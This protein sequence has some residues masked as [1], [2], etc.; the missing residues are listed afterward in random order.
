MF[1]KIT[2]L[3]AAI[4]LLAFATPVVAGESCCPSKASK[5]VVEVAK[6]DLPTP[7]AEAKAG[8]KSACCDAKKDDKCKTADK[9][10]QSG[11]CDA[12]KDCPEKAKSESAAT[13]PCSK[14]A[15]STAI[16]AVAASEAKPCCDKAP[17]SVEV[18]KAD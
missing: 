2:V 3:S 4:T 12:K 9:K 15:D 17:K 5:P 16:E 14:S 1:R 7:T 13:A 11:C 6:A 8:E 10:K 18:A